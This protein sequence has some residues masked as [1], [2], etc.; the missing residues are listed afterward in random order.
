VYVAFA[1]SLGIS[2]VELSV[3]TLALAS[4]FSSSSRGFAPLG[5]A[6]VG[7]H[8]LWL[9]GLVELGTS[10][11]TCSLGNL[12]S[13]NAF[14]STPPSGNGENAVVVQLNDGQLL[15]KNSASY[16]TDAVAPDMIVVGE[17]TGI[18]SGL[19]VAPDGPWPFSLGGVTLEI[20]DS[21][22]QQ[23]LA[24]IYFVTT[25][26]I[27]YLIPTATAPGH[28]TVKLTAFSGATILGTME[29]S[30]VSPGLYSANASGS[31]VAAGFWIRVAANGAQ[32]S[33]YLFDP[34]AAV[35]SR[36]S[37]SVSLG[38]A[39]DQVFLS[40]YGTGFRN[41]SQATATVGGLNVPVSGF[42]AVGVYQ[43]EDVVNIGPLPRS[44]AGRGPVD[45]VVTFDGAVANTITVSIR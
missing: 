15:N 13:K 40:L 20:T 11:P 29:I 25:D 31:G 41:A 28:A 24:P 21:Q 45:V 37:F 2:V 35:G 16:A 10:C 18:A 9:V 32:T 4:S 30:R 19:I 38:S 5:L 3:P 43:G 42:A 14:Q 36:L 44:L 7:P 27:G 26:A 39:S 34:L 8:S 23:R 17:A 1:T 33:D 12:I 22:G 6:L